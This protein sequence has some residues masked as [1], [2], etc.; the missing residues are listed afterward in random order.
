VSCA[1]KL[2]RCFFFETAGCGFAAFGAGQEHGKLFS[3]AHGAEEL[4]YVIDDLSFLKGRLLAARL[5]GRYGARL[6]LL[7]N[8]V[9]EL[10]EN[11][12]VIVLS[13]ENSTVELL[14][15][16]LELPET[17]LPGAGKS[18]EQKFPACDLLGCDFLLGDE[19]LR[20]V[21]VNC[22]VATFTEALVYVSSWAGSVS[23]RILARRLLASLRPMDSKSPARNCFWAILPT[24]EAQRD[25]CS[26]KSRA[27]RISSNPE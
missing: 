22:A 23:L 5:A 3:V 7:L 16:R 19:I 10:G 2:A 1:A 12:W 18:A 25:Q 6:A 9:L 11:G 4:V 21:K 13:S 15:F 14:Q 17:T 20:V 26:C 27:L 8:E 24:S